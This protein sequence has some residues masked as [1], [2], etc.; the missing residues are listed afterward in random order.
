MTTPD[1]RPEVHLDIVNGGITK[2]DNFFY[3]LLVQNYRVCLADKPDFVLF[4]HAGH[5]HRLLNAVRIFWTQ[6][7]YPA[8]FSECDYALTTFR[9]QNER[10]YRLPFYAQVMEPGDLV[11]PAGLD[12]EKIAA[13]KTDFCAFVASY[14]NK[15]TTTRVDFF[16]RLSKYKKVDSG[17]RLLNNIGGPIPGSYVGKRDWLRKY[18]F[19]IAFE[20]RSVPGYVTEKLPDALRAHTVPIYWGAPDVVKDFNPASFINANDF[21]SLDS[22][23]E[24]VAKVDQDPQLYLKY[25]SAPPYHGNQPNEAMD[26]TKLLAFFHR[27]FTTPIEPVAARQWR[28]RWNRWVLTQRDKFEKIGFLGHAAPRPPPA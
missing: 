21:A 10:E 19:H 6:E 28:F 3:R 13:E 14:A 15:N 17:G 12:Y 22:L 20:N 8:D 5:K 27:I 23:A 18:K 7:A 11:R 4:N 9:T 16:H 25:L 26:R 1:A 2:N 24:H